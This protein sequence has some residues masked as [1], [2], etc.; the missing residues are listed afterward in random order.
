MNEETKSKMN[1]EELE[2]T[3]D[4]ALALSRDIYVTKI[5][6]TK[7]TVGLPALLHCAAV[8]VLTAT[9]MSGRQEDFEADWERLTKGMGEVVQ[10]SIPPELVELGEK[11]GGIRAKAEKELSGGVEH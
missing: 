7:E 6:G 8:M 2:A 11:L 4:A 10:S 3:K 5:M 9:I 1:S